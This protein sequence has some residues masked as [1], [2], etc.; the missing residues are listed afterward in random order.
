M[1]DPKK[2]ISPFQSAV[3]AVDSKD[4]IYK[5]L[6]DQYNTVVD[7]V[8]YQNKRT[9][10]LAT[11]TQIDV[12]TGK[13]FT[14]AIEYDRLDIG[15]WSEK[16]TKEYI[17]KLGVRRRLLLSG[18]VNKT[19]VDVTVPVL[20]TTLYNDHGILI[21]EADLTYGEDRTYST[22][23]TDFGKA[24]YLVNCTTYG[25]VV[26]YTGG[27]VIV[28]HL[29]VG[30]T[31]LLPSDSDLKAGFRL[32]R[33]N[34]PGESV[35][36]KLPVIG[37]TDKWTVLIE[38]VDNLINNTPGVLWLKIELSDFG[39]YW[40][41]YDSTG[42]IGTFDATEV[43]T[44]T[45]ESVEGALVVRG[46]L[47]NGETQ[48]LQFEPQEPVDEHIFQRITAY[49]NNPFAT[50]FQFEMNSTPVEVPVEVD[51]NLAVNNT[52]Y[53]HPL[54]NALTGRIDA[55][56]TLSDLRA[57]NYNEAGQDTYKASATK[58]FDYGSI[59]RVV[60]MDNTKTLIPE[61]KIVDLPNLIRTNKIS[62]LVFEI[63]S[64]V[65]N[66]FEY[67]TYVYEIVS[68]DPDND[69]MHTIISYRGVIL[70]ENE[71]A[72]IPTSDTFAF[73]IS[74]QYAN[75]TFNSAMF[76]LDRPLNDTSKTVFKQQNLKV[77]VYMKGKQVLPEVVYTKS[78][79][80][81]IIG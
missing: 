27:D 51:V 80:N 15:L 8:D 18:G 55:P 64:F 7:K 11:C 4:P 78:L 67:G 81:L 3:N 29:N 45:L 13:P 68:V 20:T 40:T 71:T 33:T 54:S 44:L 46:N 50:T 30:R 57:V 16:N 42:V 76:S 65:K 5:L 52:I 35:Q 21:S 23:D 66:G 59:D 14:R 69:T 53:A 79:T 61:I 49:S 31:T 28:N 25:N 73:Q 36:I 48:D 2:L 37:N 10:T 22:V 9:N 77:G 39:D 38:S 41:V 74:T 47:V 58:V 26:T 6:I 62:K 56:L 1:F 12:S 75:V 43:N 63:Y 17:D 72:T 19:T 70:E 24:Y 32:L 60:L 34:Q